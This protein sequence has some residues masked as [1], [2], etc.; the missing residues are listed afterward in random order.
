MAVMMIIVVAVLFTNI[1]NDNDTGMRQNI[2]TKG[3]TANANINALV[4]E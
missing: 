1:I 4:P 2:E 3:D